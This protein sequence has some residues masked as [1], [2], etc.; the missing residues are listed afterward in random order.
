MP[1]RGKTALIT[2]APRRLGR[3]IALAAAE[4]GAS[5]VA[6]YLTSEREAEQLR[7]ELLTRGAKCW[8]VRAD[9]GTDADVEGLIQR[10]ASASGRPV[11][12]LVNNASVFPADSLATLSRARLEQCL[13]VNAWAPLVLCRSFA[14]QARQGQIVNLLDEKITGYRFAHVSYQV[15]KHALE[16]LTR[17][18]AL[19]LAPGIAVNAVAP[20]LV[21]PPPDQDEDWLARQARAVV[22]LGRP[23]AARDVAEAVVFLLSS[24]FLTGQTIF[25]DGGQHLL[26]PGGGPHLH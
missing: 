21:L 16:L 17:M 26:E 15:S 3:A 24:G 11:S 22:P 6:H 23:G 1:L 4:A 8:L 19:E 12:L 10:A 7:Q 5:I 14:S 18:L 25:V 20:G 9:L 13:G 2:G